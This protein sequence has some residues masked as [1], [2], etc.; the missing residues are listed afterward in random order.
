MLL[1]YCS[2]PGNPYSMG[3]VST[4]DLFKLTSLDQL[5][6]L[7]QTLFTILKNRLSY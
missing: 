1:R 6:L 4:V 2:I 7:L 5:V 3:R